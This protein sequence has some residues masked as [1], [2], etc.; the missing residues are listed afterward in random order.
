M[1]VKHILWPAIAL[2]VVYQCNKVPDQ[3][4]Q[5]TRAE[6]VQEAVA[7]AKHR[8]ADE[9]KKQLRDPSS[10]EFAETSYEDKGNFIDITM[11]FR[12]R[13]GFGGM[14]NGVAVAKGLLDGK[15][16]DVQI[17]E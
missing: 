1:K 4:A 14:N 13:N 11:R 3:P 15:V 12:S 7:N 2:L 9:I 6:I 10:F 5:L 8:M 17:V 16:V